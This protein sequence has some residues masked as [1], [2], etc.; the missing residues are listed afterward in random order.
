LQLHTGLSQFLGL[1]YQH[2]GTLHDVGAKSGQ[3]VFVANPVEQALAQFV[4]QRFDAAA[5]RGLRQVQFDSR[6][7]ER[8]CGGQFNQMPKLNQSHG[9]S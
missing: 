8:S 9:E 1:V 7:A 5:Q 4:L 3:L 2:A 6:L